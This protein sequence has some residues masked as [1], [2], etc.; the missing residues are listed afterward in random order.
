MRSMYPGCLVIKSIDVT[1]LKSGC[2]KGQSEFEKFLFEFVALPFSLPQ[3]RKA[4]QS[5][6][7]SVEFVF[8]MRK[9]DYFNLKWGKVNTKHKSQIKANAFSI[10]H[11]VMSEINGGTL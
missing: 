10:G 6:F 5:L 1:R 2:K 8:G 11:Q 3:I 9:N 4:T 7:N